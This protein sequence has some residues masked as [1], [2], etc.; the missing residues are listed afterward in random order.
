ML[1]ARAFD[2]SPPSL[3]PRYRRE[4][5]AALVA[6]HAQTL[7]SMLDQ[8]AV[9]KGKDRAQALDLF[10]D[11][12]TEV[13]DNY[14]RSVVGDLDAPLTHRAYRFWSAL[15]IED[16]PALLNLPET[17]T[18]QQERLYEQI[19]DLRAHTHTPAQWLAT[20]T[21]TLN[22]ITEQQN[23]IRILLLETGPGDLAATLA[24]WA[25]D[26]NVTLSLT[27]ADRHPVALEMTKEALQGF[28]HDV[29][30]PEI[31]PRD[32]SQF[33]HHSFDLVLGMDFLHLMPAASIVRL[34]VEVQHIS[35]HGFH[36]QELASLPLLP[37]ATRIACAILYDAMMHRE[38]RR[39]ARNAWSRS[40]LFV[41]AAMA[42][43]SGIHVVRNRPFWTIIHNLLPG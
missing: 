11:Y 33:A 32:L 39:A 1:D 23:H 40:D 5:G 35:V 17:P 43:A 30:L 41:M 22:H 10:E 8:V 31:D 29:T 38:A 42:D 21:P 13:W 24:H 20:L 28:A 14:Q 25:R 19:R 9:H 34:L 7:R 37:T 6:Q 2:P 26:R 27:A 15:Q 36:F 4:I 18:H 16:T 12:I 3:L